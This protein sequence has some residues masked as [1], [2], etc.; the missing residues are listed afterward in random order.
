VIIS[1]PVD[2]PDKT[3]NHGGVFALG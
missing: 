3:I 1:L 2:M